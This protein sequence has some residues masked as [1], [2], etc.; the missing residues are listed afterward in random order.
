MVEQL[1]KSFYKSDPVGQMLVHRFDINSRLRTTLFAVAVGAITF[2]AIPWLTGF[3]L[4]RPGIL[5]S[6]EDWPGLIITFVTHP[7]IYLFYCFEQR[8][9]IA[10][11]FSSYWYSEQDARYAAFLAQLSRWLEW[12]GWSPLALMLTAIGYLLHVQAVFAHPI[13]SYYDPNP[14]VLLGINAPLSALAG[15]MICMILIR[16]LIVTVALFRLFRSYTPQVHVLHP[17]RCGGLSFMGRFSIRAYYLVAILALDLSLLIVI[18]V[19]Q[20]N[21]D[22]F[23]EPSLMSLIISYLFFVPIG[24][25]LPLAPAFGAMRMARESIQNA[26]VNSAKELYLRHQIDLQREKID[27]QTVRQ[28][29]DIYRLYSLTELP[30]LPVD[31]ATFRKFLIL[32]ALSLSPLLLLLFAQP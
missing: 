15:Y 18:N 13:P 28:I 22:P 7:A 2:V 1:L 25:F 8:N 11:L 19:Q 29:L 31:S 5:S 17:D 6:L 10:K 9:M 26:L 20:V 14:V 27:E 4:P 23:T 3:L 30:L 21:R 16:Y 32:I 24:F 12:K